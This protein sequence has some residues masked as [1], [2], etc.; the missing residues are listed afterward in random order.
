M[1]RRSFIKTGSLLSAPLLFNGIPV[2]AAPST[3]NSLLDKLA[4]SA[5]GC[6][7]VLVIV[8]LNGGNDALNTYF[9]LDKWSHL[10]NARSNILMNQG[11]VLSLN[12]NSTTG[13]HPAMGELRNLYNDG[14][15]MLVQGV[16]YPNPNFSHFRATDIWF[17]ASG[18]DVTLDSGWLGRTL[19]NQYPG[20]PTGY[21]NAGMA[22]P[23][24]IQIGST[25]PFSLQGPTINMGY[26]VNNPATLLN[27]IN[28]ITDPTPNNDYGRELAFLRLMKD[29]SNAYRSV[30]QNAYNIVPPITATYPANNTLA[31]QLRIVAR[32]I[33]GGLTTPIYIVNHNNSFD[34]HENQVDVTDHTLGTHANI[35]TILSQAI[36]AFQQDLTFMNK[37]QIVTGMTHSEFGRRIKSNASMGTDHGSAAPVMFFG[38]ALNTSPSSVAGTP[39]PV[40]GMIGTSPNLPLNATVNDQVPM[41]FDFRQLYATVMK[42]WFCMNEAD[43]TTVLGSAFTRLPIFQPYTT[44][45]LDGVELMGQYFGG[46]AKLNYR[47]ENNTRYS[48][49]AVEFSSD[50]TN[51]TEI[52]RQQNLSL[53]S[54]ELYYYDHTIDAS[55]MYF[56]IAARLHDGSLSYSNILLLKGKGMQQLVSVFPNPVLNNNINIKFFKNPLTPVDITIYNV[57]GAKM[58]YN[59]FTNVG[60]VLSFRT[61]ALA[62]NAHYILEIIFEQEKVHEEIIF[63]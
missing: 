61:T 44:V 39:Y 60:S 11:S 19:D 56:R 32:L 23:L 21:P 50:G 40:P 15:L 20:F 31:S 35:L 45:P 57:A 14:K 63:Q 16:S 2:M 6:G 38:A 28:G 46:Q 17:S 43:V 48:S 13:L 7:K 3:G 51:F 33:N 36:G 58:Y 52:G 55:R 27:V 4:E 22:D 54:S 41:Q 10:T 59:R 12:N 47:V 37:A 53:N 34:T 49:F 1:K 24:A 26:N 29:Q 25:L 5:A 62:K 9:P 18:S 8:Q 42:D 30:I